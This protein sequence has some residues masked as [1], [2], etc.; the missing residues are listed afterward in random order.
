MVD[1]TNH[2]ALVLGTAP[3]SSRRDPTGTYDI[4][5]IGSKVYMIRNSIINNYSRD[6]AHNY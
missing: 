6:N 3:S 1:P 2:T 4:L 5:D